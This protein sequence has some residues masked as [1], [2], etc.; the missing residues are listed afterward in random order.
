[1][2]IL[3][4][5]E[6]CQGQKIVVLHCEAGV[7]RSIAA[8][9]GILFLHGQGPA[10]VSDAAQTLFQVHPFGNPN[11]RL[12][13]ALLETRYDPSQA[14]VIRA[15]LIEAYSALQEKKNRLNIPGQIF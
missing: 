9:L 15:Q 11:K 8:A 4:A 7:S 2:A 6:K 10:A 13:E 1:V 5:W 14:R 12:L 3:S